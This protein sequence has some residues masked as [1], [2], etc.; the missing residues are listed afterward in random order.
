V[1]NEMVLTPAQRSMVD[2]LMTVE[3]RPLIERVA[4]LLDL[5]RQGAAV[6]GPKP[7]VKRSRLPITAGFLVRRTVRNELR[8][9][10]DRGGVTYD[11]KEYPGWFESDFLLTI[12]IQTW[13]DLKY[14]ISVLDALRGLLDE[15]A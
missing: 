2:M 7:P 4:L 6:W 1:E 5:Y 8:R 9:H 13:D 3:S 15:E 11:L 12:E 14:L 10:L